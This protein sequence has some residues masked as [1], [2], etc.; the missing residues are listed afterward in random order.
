MSD[1]KKQPSQT[2]VYT[3]LLVVQVLFGVTNVV[4][5]KILGSMPALVWATIRLVVAAV[6]MIGI[7][8]AIKRPFPKGG[9]S[10]FVPLIVYTLLGVV[11]T[12]GSFLYGLQFTTATHAT[13]LNTLIP[14]ITLLIVTLR[15]QEPLNARRTVGF[16]VAFSGVLALKYDHLQKLS[17][18]ADKSLLGDLLILVNCICLGLFFSYSKKFMERHDRFWITTW[19][20]IYG[21]VGMSVL[22]STAWAGFHMPVMTPVLIGSMA[23][24]ILGGTIAVYFLNA[25]TLAHTHSSSV[26]FFGY[27]QPVVA[28]AL[29]WAWLGETITVGTVL[30]SVIIFGG[31]IIVLAPWQARPARARA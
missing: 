26:A 4:S 10:F 29:A 11:L 23:F 3:A 9:R 19:M 31:V 17:F 6:L 27:I 2:L 8:M 30:C 21:T 13:I 12:Q 28:A 1:D 7:V 20:F 25:W 16:L 5:K 18:S 24:A 15:G 14:L 22:G